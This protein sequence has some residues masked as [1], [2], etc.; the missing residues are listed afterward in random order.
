MNDLTVWHDVGKVLPN[1]GE[2]VLVATLDE[3]RGGWR[4][5]SACL[6]VR[7]EGVVPSPSEVSNRPVDF[8]F[9]APR[10]NDRRMLRPGMLW[11]LQPKPSITKEGD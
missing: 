1:V 3:L 8:Y 9:D 5:A 6:F 10:G 2:T 4:V 11:A 7:H